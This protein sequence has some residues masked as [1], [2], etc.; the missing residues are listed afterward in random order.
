MTTQVQW[1]NLKR[2]Y[3]NTETCSRNYFG[4]W[5]G[6]RKV[7]KIKWNHRKLW[8]KEKSCL[9]PKMIFKVQLSKWNRLTSHKVVSDPL[10]RIV[11]EWPVS[12]W[13]L[14]GVQEGLVIPGSLQ[15]V[16]IVKTMTWKIMQMF[17]L[18]IRSPS[19]TRDRLMT[20]STSRASTKDTQ[21]SMMP[22]SSETCFNQDLQKHPRE[23][24]WFKQFKK[25]KTLRLKT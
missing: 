22:S 9:K 2:K 13:L 16:K 12:S 21:V 23:T 25:L 8:R 10:T 7:W 19:E 17:F 3:H 4:R 14:I 5:M 18:M 24:K 1:S 15:R 11:K 20:T 6:L